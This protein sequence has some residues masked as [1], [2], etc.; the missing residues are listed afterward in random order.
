M[1]NLPAAMSPGDD[2]NASVAV[3]D[4]PT[5]GCPINQLPNEVLIH[6]FSVGNAIEEEEMDGWEEIDSEEA[7]KG[8]SEGGDD[9]LNIG[10]MVEEL[11]SSEGVT[12]SEDAVYTD[13]GL[14]L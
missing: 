5:I 14:P 8:S 13:S 1:L 9:P 2:I 7:E 6:I 4:R 11:G 12:A 10:R 3:T